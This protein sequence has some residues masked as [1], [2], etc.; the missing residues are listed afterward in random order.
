[1]ERK[2]IATLRFKQ[3]ITEGTP[4][5][6]VWFPDSPGCFSKSLLVPNNTMGEETVIVA[7]D[8][9]SSTTQFRG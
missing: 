6:E 9:R 2:R 7:M 4:L 5:Q 8:V 3:L 1:M